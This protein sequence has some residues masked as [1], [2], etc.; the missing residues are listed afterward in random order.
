MSVYFLH[1]NVQKNLRN[2]ASC[3]WYFYLFVTIFNL[4]FTFLALTSVFLT[5][6]HEFVHPNGL[7]SEEK[8]AIFADVTLT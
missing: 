8:I 7:L 1:A 6:L 5:L 4:L 2:D 3:G